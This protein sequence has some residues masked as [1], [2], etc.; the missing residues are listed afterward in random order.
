[1]LARTPD[2]YRKLRKV[3]TGTLR[4]CSDIW[5]ANNLLPAADVV[6]CTRGR[7]WIMYYRPCGGQRVNDKV[8]MF[9][10]NEDGTVSLYM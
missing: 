9:R 1:M 10:W 7:C 5:N 6:R 3:Y 8:A 2:T 4:E